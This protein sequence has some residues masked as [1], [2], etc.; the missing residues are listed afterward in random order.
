MDQVLFVWLHGC[1]LNNEEGTMIQERSACH[2][3]GRGMLAGE[4]STDS[5]KNSTDP[6]NRPQVPQNTHMKGF[7]S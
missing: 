7:P 2:S 1:S 6:W 5:K 4:G 3:L